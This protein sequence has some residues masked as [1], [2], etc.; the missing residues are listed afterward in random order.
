MP[1]H[2]QRPLVLKYGRAVHRQ[3][4]GCW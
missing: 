4:T 1:T 3:A 2:P